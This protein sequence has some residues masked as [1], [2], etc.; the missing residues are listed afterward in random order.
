[1]RRHPNGI[2]LAAAVRARPAVADPAEPPA[3]VGPCLDQAPVRKAS[4]ETPE[5]VSVK[6]DTP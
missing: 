3:V 5:R 1:M 2:A 6:R 4:R